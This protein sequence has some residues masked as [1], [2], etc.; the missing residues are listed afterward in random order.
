V[1]AGLGDLHERRGEAELALAC[2][3]RATELDPKHAGY[4]RTLGMAQYR[5]GDLMAALFSLRQSQKLRAGQEDVAK[6]MDEIA[7]ARS[8]L[9]GPQGKRG[10][11]RENGDPFAPPGL[12]RA[13]FPGGRAFDPS[14]PSPLV[15]NP[16]EGLPVPGGARP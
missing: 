10:G 12:P 5:K 11:D 16:L 3:R 13:G 2:H 14:R 15:P 9:A 6:V 1:L 7:L 4:W 8:P